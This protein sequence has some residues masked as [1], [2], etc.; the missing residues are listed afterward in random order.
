MP[1]SISFQPP[2]RRDVA[3]MTSYESAGVARF[4]ISQGGTVGCTAGGLP[5]LPGCRR[6]TFRHALMLVDA[7]FLHDHPVDEFQVHLP[8]V[9]IRDRWST[10]SSFPRRLPSLLPWMEIRSACGACGTC[11]PTGHGKAGSPRATLPAR[12][13]I[14]H[15]LLP[16]TGRSFLSPQA[17]GPGATGPHRRSCQDGAAGRRSCARCRVPKVIR[18]S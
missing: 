9:K 6:V 18:S 17:A 13:Q 10:G 4:H 16:R 12:P 11:G 7:P 14:N 8:Y 3:E 5:G 2:G 15:P 1:I